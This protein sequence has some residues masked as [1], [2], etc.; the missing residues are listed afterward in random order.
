VAIV[1]GDRRG[2]PFFGWR[3]AEV[4]NKVSPDAEAPEKVTSA[5]ETN[6][7]TNVRSFHQKNAQVFVHGPA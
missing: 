3:S 1:T 4:S 5:E 6:P 2:T 7:S